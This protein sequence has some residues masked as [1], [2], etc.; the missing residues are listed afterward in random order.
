VLRRLEAGLQKLGIVTWIW[1]LERG[2]TD[3]FG[4]ASSLLGL[5]AGRFDGSFGMYLAALHPADRELARVRMVAA[6]KGGARED[7]VDERVIWPDGSVHWIDARTLT[8]V[9]A[10]GRPL[11]IIGR[12]SQ[13]QVREHLRGDVNDPEAR[14]RALVEQVPLPVSIVRGEIFAYANQRFAQLYGWDSAAEVIG[15]P[16][17]EFI[18]PDEREAHRRRLLRRLAGE[19]EP[20]AYTR[21]MLR[22]DGSELLVFLAV[23]RVQLADGPGVM[24]FHHDMSEVLQARRELQA[25]QQR[26]ARYLEVAQAVLVVLDADGRVSM[27]NPFGQQLLG[28]PEHELRGQEWFATCVPAEVRESRRRIWDEVMRGQRAPSPVINLPTLTRDGRQLEIAWSAA[29]LQDGQGRF[30]GAVC[31][32]LDVTE[33]RLAQARLRT[34][35][36]GLEQR[37]A[38]RTAELEAARDEA[39]A[40][41]RAR[42]RFVAH[43]SHEIRTPM[44]AIIGMSDLALRLP[45]LGDRARSYLANIRRASQSLLEIVNDILDFSKIDAGQLHIEPRGFDLS[46]LLHRILSVIGVRAVEKGLALRLQVDPAVPRQLL[47]DDLRIG[48]VLINLCG[49]AVKFTDQGQVQVGAS[50][51]RQEGERVWVRFTVRDS[52]IGIDADGCSRLFAPFGQLDASST[53]RYGGTGLGLAISRQLVELMGGHIGVE[54]QPGQGSEFHFDLPLETRRT[55]HTAAASL[56]PRPDEAPAGSAGRLRGARLLVVEDNELNQIIARDLLEEVC[57]AR[58]TVAV[59]GRDALDKLR[60]ADF[61]AVLMDVE[62]PL[63][64]GY[65]ATRLLRAEPRWR[66]LPVIAMTAHAMAQNRDWCLAAGMDDFVSKPFDPAV[67]V[68]VL[69]RHLSGA[70]ATPVPDLAP[71]PAA[72]Q[73]AAA[74]AVDLEVGLQ[75]AMGMPVLYQALQR[76]FVVSESTSARRIADALGAGDRRLAARLAHTMVSS[77]GAIGA[78]RLQETARALQLAIEARADDPCGVLLDRYGAHLEQVLVQL[79]EQMAP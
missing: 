41:V 50:L 21:R 4:D 56:V 40:A 43:M 9:D 7:S 74:P 70:P 65:E 64:D 31:S 68:Q 33:Q 24:S 42:G 3:W 73:A 11:R 5:E 48:Q 60:E 6:L 72:G 22:R 66:K 77:A 8:E 1:D 71:A 55:L 30:T 52:G 34:L 45:S 2:S 32:G 79:G 51:L 37:V 54:S 58:V 38:E 57:G 10:A 69:V 36:A 53:R 35:N 78:L 26:A 44:N 59:N 47:G 13:A 63:M 46:E 23:T 67:L 75:R 61:D 14:L 16:A 17:A 27:I 19:P 29:L 76:Q 15:R 20:E 18:P 25:E 62:M 28:W 49:N 39:E 12:L